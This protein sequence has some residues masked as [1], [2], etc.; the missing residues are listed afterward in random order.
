MVTDEPQAFASGLAK[1]GKFKGV[2]NYLVMVARKGRENDEAVGYCGEKLVL[3]MQQLGLNTCWVGLTFKNVK[4]AYQVLAG[5]ELKLVIA[6]GYGATQGVQ[7]RQKKQL[8]DFARGGQDF[9]DWFV[10]G[11]EA[12]MLAPTAVNQQKFEFV[13][14]PDRRVKAQTLFSLSSYTHI[15]LGIAKCHFEIGA[16]T[17]H[18]EWA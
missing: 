16:G 4:S 15:D 18:F 1:Y 17:E 11:V 6:C 7:H 12:A 5:E 14:L 8:M 13:L 9:P 3:L 2:S 10:R